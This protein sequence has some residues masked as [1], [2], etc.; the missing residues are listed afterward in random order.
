MSGLG[1][2]NNG[3]QLPP[4]MTPPRLA[5]H[6]TTD[7][8]RGR[9]EGYVSHHTAESGGVQPEQNPYVNTIQRLPREG[10]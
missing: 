8:K 6:D 10:F 1:F 2:D 7:V 5:N 3:S 4:Q 9:V